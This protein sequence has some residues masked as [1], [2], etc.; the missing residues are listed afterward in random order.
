MDRR[1]VEKY[2][3]NS[4]NESELE[5]VL[6]WF[7]DSA[8]TVDGKDILHSIWEEIPENDIEMT[9]NFDILLNKIHHDINTNKTKLLIEPPTI[10][11]AKYGRGRFLMNLIRN[12]AAILLLPVLGLG[13]FFANKYYSAKSSQLSSAQSYNEV[14][15]SFDAITKITLPEGSTVWLNHNSSLLYPATFSEKLRKVEL[16]GEG[17]FDVTHNPRSPFIVKAGDIQVVAYGT[18]FNVM[19]YPDENKIETTL[20]EG[21]VE[22]IKASS[23]EKGTSL[24]KMNPSDHTVYYKENNEIVTKT[25]KDERYIS[26]KEGKLIFTAEPLDEVVK[27]LSRWFNVDI[28]IKDHELDDITIT[29]TFVHETLPQVMGLLSIVSPVTYSISGRNDIGKGSFSKAE[30]ILSS[31]NKISKIPKNNLIK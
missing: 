28:Q 17:Y 10:A 16:K 25:I 29:A 3:N 23:D 19:A 18:T 26:W 1:L 12:A 21:S 6:S 5:T 13:L 4:C 27:K 9:V 11:H 14:F 7:R 15:S 22:M 31:K 2:L 30:V 8:D 24:Y 20:I